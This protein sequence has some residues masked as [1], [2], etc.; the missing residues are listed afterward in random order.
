MMN[1]EINKLGFV[2]KWINTQNNKWYIGSHAGDIDDGYIASGVLIKKALKKYGLNLFIREILYQGPDFKKYEETILIETDAANDSLSYNLKN[3]SIGGDVWIGRKDTPEYQEYLKKISQPREK[4]PMF[5]KTHTNEIKKII[6][7]KNLGNT[8]WN[9]GLSNY[10]SEEHKKAFNRKGSK[11]SQE[12]KLKMS[13]KRIGSNNSNAKQISINNV[14]YKS[15]KEAS[16]ST[17]LS[18]YK[19]SRYYMD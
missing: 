17:G 18:Y 10:M 9:K 19:I 12:T 6:S 13:E 16:E 14:T 7:E 1:I 3:T 11:H 2:Y 8:A 5:G 15:L 4:N